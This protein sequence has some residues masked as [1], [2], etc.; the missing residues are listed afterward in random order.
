[1][2]MKIIFSQYVVLNRASIEL[3]VDKD[4]FFKFTFSADFFYSCSLD[5][6]GGVRGVPRQVL[7]SL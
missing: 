3:L 7:V 1:M 6:S 4:F 2:R 5:D